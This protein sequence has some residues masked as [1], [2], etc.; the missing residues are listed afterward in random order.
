MKACLFYPL[1]V[2]EPNWAAGVD[3]GRLEVCATLKLG[4]FG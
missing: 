1:V 4:Y 3:Q 2:Q